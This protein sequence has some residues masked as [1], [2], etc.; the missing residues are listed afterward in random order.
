M[1]PPAVLLVNLGSPDS[2][3]V[4]DVARYLREFLGDERV[5]DKPGEPWRSLLVNRIIVPRRAPKSAH[6]YASVWTDKGSPLIATSVAVKEKLAAKLAR[7]TP[8]YLAMRYGNPSIGSVLDRMVADGVSN[9]L[10]FP[11]YPH[12]AMSSW[13]TVVV[14]V[15]EE[16]ARHGSALQFTTVQPFYQDPDYIEALFETAKPYFEQ[17]H[18]HVLF[19]FHSL[20]QRHLRKADTSGAHCLTVKD[21]CDTCSPVHATC[22]RAQ[23]LKTTRAL[24]NRAGIPQNKY[25]VSF[26]SRLA[27]EPWLTPYTDY[28]LE[29]FPK[30]GVKNLLVICPAFVADCLETVEEISVEGR[31]IFL[32]A[33]GQK[34]QQ[35]PCP[36]EQAPYI[37]FLFDR[38]VAWRDEARGMKSTNVAERT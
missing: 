6:A 19:S 27:G 4:P 21:C 9:F 15:H 3:S 31:D 37:D 1:S 24:V 17:P 34:F 30:E 16:A 36:N 25:S 13:E 32:K 8:V 20:P 38:V 5:I 23:A 10:L 14:K 11:Q 22:Y 26:Q 29:R 33:G 18:D 28:E 12:Y 7:E 35:I 2:T